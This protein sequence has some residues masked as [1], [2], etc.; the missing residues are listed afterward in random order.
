METV[1]H[2]SQLIRSGKLREW[3]QYSI[4]PSSF[5]VGNYGSGDSTASFPAHSEWETTGVETVQH[6]SQLI[7]SGKLREWRQYSIVPSSFGVGNYG[8]GDS[9]A[10]FPAHSEWET[11]GVETVQ[12]R[13]QLIRS[14]KLREW[15]QYSIV[16]S[17]FGVGNYGSGD[18][19]A[20]FP[21]HSE[22]ETTGVETV[23]H[24]SQLIRSGKLRELRQYSIV[25]RL[26]EIRM[27]LSAPPYMGSIFQR[28]ILQ[29]GW[30]C[31]PCCPDT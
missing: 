20:S 24:R 7:R 2:C 28:Y 12:H 17:S 30:P 23:Q 5:G 19:T 6:C 29:P 26:M 4:V 22:W 15:R 21:A 13:S 9:T 14:G 10:S 31:C 3:R 16:P 27:R 11:T 18:S 25:P 1:Q 8:S